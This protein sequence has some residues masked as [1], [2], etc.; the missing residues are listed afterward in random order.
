MQQEASTITEEPDEYDL[1]ARE[2]DLTT[3]HSSS[4]DSFHDF[5][6]CNPTPLPPNTTALEWWL[7]EEQRRDYPRL[8]RMAIDILSIPAMS[9]EPER[10]FS[11]SRRTITWTRAS[12]SGDTI[13]MLECLK[14]WIREN[15]SS[16][17]GFAITEE[18]E[19]GGLTIG[20]AEGGGEVN[21]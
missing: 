9:A 17:L 16:G 12:L 19:G 8:S 5:I 1:L 4:R 3:S 20:E 7:R 2:L 10:I 15:I 6:N 18:A 11:G 14:S 21:S 13:E